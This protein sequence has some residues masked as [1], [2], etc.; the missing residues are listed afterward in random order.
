MC[1]FVCG[2]GVCAL[3]F[4]LKF[5]VL[6]SFFPEIGV[7]SRVLLQTNTSGLKE[8]IWKG[9][10]G[11]PAWNPNPLG[12]SCLEPKPMEVTLVVW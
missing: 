5:E 3:E 8:E 1:H 2:A 11:V 4:S 7:K 12:G 9:L 6:N 10:L